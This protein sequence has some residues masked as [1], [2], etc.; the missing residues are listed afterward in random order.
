MEL[1]TCPNHPGNLRLTREACAKQYQAGKKT[2][3][4]DRLYL[5]K[6]C[7]LG[8][9]HAGE[10]PAPAQPKERECLRC[11]ATGR[12]LVRNQICVSCYNRERELL[13]G[14]YRRRSPPRNLAL[15]EHEIHLAGGFQ[16]E[17]VLA[18]SSVE[19]LLWAA[20]AHPGQPIVAASRT[21]RLSWSALC[22]SPQMSLLPGA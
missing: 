14:R 20:R 5:C 9:E 13:T 1:F 17:V 18:A 22:A 6:G 8:A 3:P 21:H 7:A 10:A 19:A 11:G 4:W 12:R 15:S 16:P 2:K